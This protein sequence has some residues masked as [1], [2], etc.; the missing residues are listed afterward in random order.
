LRNST[1]YRRP[2]ERREMGGGEVKKKNRTKLESRVVMI[3]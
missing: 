1:T 3:G 2:G